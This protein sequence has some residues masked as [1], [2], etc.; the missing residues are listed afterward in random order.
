[1][2]GSGVAEHM[3]LR[4][5]ELWTAY[6]LVHMGSTKVTVQYFEHKTKTRNAKMKLQNNTFCLAK[7]NVAESCAT[8]YVITSEPLI[9][10]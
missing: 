10:S 7:K 4:F 1:L 6:V 5:V 9:L 8:I 3:T 2:Y